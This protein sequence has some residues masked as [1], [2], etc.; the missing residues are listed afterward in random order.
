MNVTQGATFL[1]EP[2]PDEILR[3]VG[4]A[5]TDINV[6]TFWSL[7]DAYPRGKL[8]YH[9]GQ[10][11]M[12]KLINELADKGC[13]VQTLICDA[14]SRSVIGEHITPMLSDIEVTKAFIDR[15]RN[16][17]VKV[18]LLSELVDSLHQQSEDARSLSERAVRG[19]LKFRNFIQQRRPPDAVL[20][21]LSDF[22]AY[23]DLNF[24]G[25]HEST[26][27][28]L[29]VL[30]NEFPDV[31]AFELLASLFASHRRP[32]WFDAFWLGD[33]AAWVAIQAATKGT[34]TLI[35]EANRS[36][37]SW[38]TH[39]CFLRIGCMQQPAISLDHWPA[40][41]FVT[42]LLSTTGEEAM[43][44]DRR[45]EAIFLYHDPKGLMSRL[46]KATPKALGS[47]RSWFLPKLPQNTDSE[48]VRKAVCDTVVSHT[49]KFDPGFMIRNK[50]AT[51]KTRVP[52]SDNLRIGLCLS[53]GGF[54]ATFYH[55]GVIR[56][57]QQL[58]LL[59][60]VTGVYAVS[61]GSILAGHLAKCWDSYSQP[62]ADANSFINASRP[63]FQM[64]Q[65]DLRGRIVR[66]LLAFR[67]LTGTG[68]IPRFIENY[69]KRVGGLDIELGNLP[70]SPAFSF[71]ATSMK[72]GKA[73]SFSRDGYHD[74]QHLLRC[75]DWPLARAVA[76]S[77][78]FPPVFLPIP[79][80]QKDLSGSDGHDRGVEYLTDGG[81]YDNLGLSRL[82]SDEL[83]RSDE[84]WFSV[85]L[86]SDASAPFG[87]SLNDKF[88]LMTTRALRTTDILMKRVAELEAAAN[89]SEYEP[90][91]DRPRP[92]LV[93]AE[94]DTVVS[95]NDE[96]CLQLDNG[97]FKVQDEAVQKHLAKI[98]TDLDEFSTLEIAALMRHGY[99]VALNSL[100]Q[101]KLV[102]SNFVP[103]DPWRDMS[104][105]VDDSSKDV[106]PLPSRTDEPKTE[107]PKTE[108]LRKKMEHASRRRLRLFK[109]SDWTSWLL[110]TYVA[111]TACA[112]AAYYYQFA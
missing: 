100:T 106:S 110:L 96:C 72:T 88:R 10:L 51:C 25:L 53:G 37:Y 67:W 58:D 7:E 59:N 27:S 16:R 82:A 94:I 39:K 35:L 26:R 78:A 105:P 6:L 19:A 71:L 86:V 63:L 93:H 56:L 32:K 55:L 109:G 30:Q 31:P 92:Y 3:V 47:Y 81:V 91:D 62:K 104:Q 40:M 99:E 46:E 70:D 22:R 108:E 50:Q 44:L 4:G 73:V 42:P 75:P 61:G 57:L 101:A 14:S 87:S 90:D 95:P 84:K 36:A 20:E 34:N 11:G 112:L 49:A 76:A 1:C 103:E 45:D 38:L 28:Y 74:G 52:S 64:G 102:P 60:R 18:K 5:A 85:V 17:S 83:E 48:T 9:L 54:R 8:R 12:T 77:S 111:V 23:S 41:C 65:G 89:T 43:Q 69:F 98:R 29:T 79:I 33:V 97:R 13:S 2:D 80:A 107:E 68:W 66:R 15:Q 21:S 24:E